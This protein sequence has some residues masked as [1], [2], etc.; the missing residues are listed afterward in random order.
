MYRILLVDDERIIREGIAAIIDWEAHDLMFLGAVRNGIEAYDAIV[1]EHPQIVITDIKMPVLDG[2]ELI[3]KV[4]GEF[5]E[6][7]FIVLSGYSEFELA[8]EAMRHGV[9]HY[10][11]KP[12]NEH[13]IIDVLQNVKNE[14]RQNEQKEIFIRN[15]RENLEKVMPLVREQFIHDFITNRS[16]TKDEYD[17]FCKLLG[18]EE[19]PFRMILLQPDGEY[20]YEEMF[21][22]MSITDN[23]LGKDRYFSTIMKNQILTLV[24]NLDDEQI[25]EAINQVKKTFAYYH[26]LEVSIAYSEANTFENAQLV[27]KEVQECL[28]YS[29]YLG[30]GSIIT[31]K[32][33]EPNI[34]MKDSIIFDFDTVAMSIK[35]GN[36]EVTQTQVINFFN[37]LQIKQIGINLSKIYAMELFLIIIR[38]SRTERMENHIDKIVDLQRMNSLAQV[39]SFIQE[40]AD[41]VAMANRERIVNTHNKLIRMIVEYVENHMENEDLSLKWLASEKIFMNVGY[42]SKLF[43]KETGEKFSHY[44][45]KVRMEKAKQLIKESTDDRIREVAQKVGLGNNPQYFSQLFKK[46]TGFAPSEYKKAT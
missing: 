34:S 22:L 26:D 9:K 10:L 4:K 23:L 37:Q 11:L 41:Q 24:Y 20:G 36:I 5:P 46:Y 13:K 25:I 8:K 45:T 29:F 3:A 27:Y 43:I 7:I 16:Y 17:Y 38:Q 14:L 42:L 39:Q 31:K 33:I 12:C 15:N 1:R 21:G 6:I 44:L 35:S 40:I 18:M 2:L 19:R 32:D 30:P 28:K